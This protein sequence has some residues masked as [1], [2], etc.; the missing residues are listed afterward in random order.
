MLL[1]WSAMLLQ[2]EIINIILHCNN[3]L[4]IIPYNKMR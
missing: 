4:N 2:C 1:I 3:P